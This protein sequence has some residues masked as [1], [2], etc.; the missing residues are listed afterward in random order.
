[1]RPYEHSWQV[2]VFSAIL[3]THSDHPNPR[4]S[5]LSLTTATYARSHGQPSPAGETSLRM[6]SAMKKL[7]PSRRSA[8]NEL[9]SFV[10]ATQIQSVA[11]LERFNWD[12]AEAADAFFSG[13]VDVDELVAAAVPSAPAVDV[14]TLD[15]WF[16]RYADESE[17]DSMLDDGIQTFYT[18]LGVDTQDLV[19]LLISWKM[20]AA[21]MC[22]YTREEWRR[23]MSALGVSTTRQLRHKLDELREEV[24]DQRSPAF[25]QF[26]MFCFDYAKERAKKSIELDVC[27][28]VWDLVL[29]GSEFPLVKEFSDFLR[30]A[31]VPVVT[32]DMWA[33]TLVFFCSVDADLSNFEV[34][35]AWPVVVDDFVEAKMAQ[36]KA[37]K[38]EIER[39]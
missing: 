10:G 29:V 3:D 19:V 23:G 7:S 15:V 1:M 12:V 9:C 5:K 33:Q 17:E 11:L 38:S 35:D 32:K 21:E 20:E 31:K 8:A 13:D 6:A 16:D 37:L 28:S 30:G 2:I 4:P 22:V 26:Y 18:E 34:G 36:R 14:R 39:P 25:Q 24:A 27:L